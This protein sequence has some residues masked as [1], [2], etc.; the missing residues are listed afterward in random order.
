M[1]SPV[2]ATEDPRIVRA[3]AVLA[4]VM[5]PEV[6]VL[7]VV[8]LGI[9]RAVRTDALGLSID[10][11]PTYTGCPATAAIRL[12]V[13]TAIE[14][15]GLGRPRIALVNSP[16]WTT[17]WIGAAARERLREYGIA[18]PSGKASAVRAKL[19]AP[20]PAVPCPRCASADTR[21]TSEF[22]STACKALYACNACAEPFEYFKCI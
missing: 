12:D 7:S 14:A 6:P 2:P 10:L 9:V 5:D 16:A 20:D 11:T 19:F 15:A 13:E 21:K 22:G 17:D 4:T 18:P 8:D 1:V 3:W